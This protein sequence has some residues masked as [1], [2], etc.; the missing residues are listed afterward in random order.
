MFYRFLQS[1]SSKKFSLKISEKLCDVLTEKFNFFRRSSAVYLCDIQDIEK[2]Y[3][4]L[5]WLIIQI[6]IVGG[7][8]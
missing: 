3:L 1:A 8:F 4:S 7:Y 6:D 2:I 5:K